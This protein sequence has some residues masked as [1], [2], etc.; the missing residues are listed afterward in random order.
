MASSDCHLLAWW[1][2]YIRCFMFGLW[3]PSHVSLLFKINYLFLIV[4]KCMTLDTGSWLDANFQCPPFC[5][6]FWGNRNWR[7]E[8][9]LD[10]IM[11]AS[12]FY[13]VCALFWCSYYIFVVFLIFI[14]NYLCHIT[15]YILHDTWYNTSYARLLFRPTYLPDIIINFNYI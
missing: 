9:L 1:S 11:H 3:V 8:N 4:S 5:I 13:A 14:Y 10:Q 6:M 7:K 12:S 15:Y 2:E